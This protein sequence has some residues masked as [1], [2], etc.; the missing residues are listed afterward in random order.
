MKSLGQLLTCIQR[1]IT[2]LIIIIKL[3]LDKKLRHRL[4]QKK[5]SI[6]LILKVDKKQ[7][8]PLKTD[9]KKTN[10]CIRYWTKKVE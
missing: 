4:L 9:Y 5:K 3:F 1:K 8:L 10:R 6:K 7:H 2:K